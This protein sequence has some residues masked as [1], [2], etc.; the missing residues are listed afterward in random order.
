MRL[1]LPDIFGAMEDDDGTNCGLPGNS[2][3]RVAQNE[4]R[5]TR[6]FP[7]SE[8]DEM[9]PPPVRVDSSLRLRRRHT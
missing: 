8:P 4:I 7:P 1:D 9:I 3:V 6:W 2:E 5:P